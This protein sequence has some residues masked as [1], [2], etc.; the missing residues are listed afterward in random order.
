MTL[1]HEGASRPEPSI[2]REGGQESDEQLVSKYL[3]SK[4]GRAWAILQKRYETRLRN[5]LRKRTKNEQDLEEI[6][7]ET[8]AK[9]AQ[10][11]Y[12]FDQK[13]AFVTWLFR[14]G[15]NLSIDHLRSRMTRSFIQPDEMESLEKYA[16]DVSVGPE[17]IVGKTEL[18]TIL[19][20]A[21]EVLSPD[22]RETFILGAIFGHSYK[23]IAKKLGITEKTVATRIFYAKEKLRNSLLKE[24]PD[25]EQAA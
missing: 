17:G 1:R 21:L 10:K 7:N 20:D 22:M 4:D 15:K 25:L 2:S 16:D 24:H 9:A 3:H 19:M 13:A 12:T 5:F 14:I 11:L 23:E 18:G 6:V 8:F